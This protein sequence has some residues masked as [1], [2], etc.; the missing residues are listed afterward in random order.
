MVKNK[1][2]EVVEEVEVTE[3]VAPVAKK[4]ARNSAN[5]TW[6]G[7]TRTYTRELHG[8]DFEALAE[9]FAGKKGGVV[10]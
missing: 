6:R 8:E 4:G 10:A 7:G 9:E 2:K 3:E 5:V 1:T